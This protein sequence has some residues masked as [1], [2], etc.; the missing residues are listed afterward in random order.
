MKLKTRKYVAVH[1]FSL[2]VGL[3]TMYG[4]HALFL[5]KTKEC[6]CTPCSPCPSDDEK[7]EYIKSQGRKYD[8]SSE[9]TLGISLTDALDRLDHNRVVY[10]NSL[11]GMPNGVVEVKYKNGEQ[12]KKDIIE[13]KK[14]YEH[15]TGHSLKFN[16]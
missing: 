3:A 14:A 15:A 4:I 10:M 7:I 16:P 11:Y 5:C 2:L 13:L 8:E 12:D 6:V 1:V 9:N